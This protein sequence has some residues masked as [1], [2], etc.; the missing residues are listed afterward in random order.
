MTQSEER[1]HAS[2]VGF[3]I[4]LCAAASV[5]TFAVHPASGIAAAQDEC[6]WQTVASLGAGST[7]DAAG[8][9][10]SEAQVFYVYGGLSPGTGVSRAG[11]SVFTLQQHDTDPELLWAQRLDQ[12]AAQERWAHSG[13][14]A[15]RAGETAIYWIGG[16]RN[17]IRSAVITETYRA[18]N[19]VFEYLPAGY[20]QVWQEI[21]TIGSAPF[22]QDHAAVYY[23]TQRA[24]VIHGGR[25]EVVIDNHGYEVPDRPRA[26]SDVTYVL[27]YDPDSGTWA[28]EDFLTKSNG[29]RVYGHSLHYDED[30]A[31]LL[32]FGG[33]GDGID[34]ESTLWALDLANGLE[35]ASWSPLATEGTKPLGRF[36]HAASIDPA[37]DRLIVYGGRGRARH[38][39]DTWA[40]ELDA[41]PPQWRQLQPRPSAGAR[42]GAI[43]YYSVDRDAI[44]LAGGTGLDDRPQ[45]S[46]M[47]LRGCL[48]PL[49]TPTPT[50]SPTGT[51]TARSTAT[52]SSTPTATRAPATTTSTSTT[53]STAA[54]SATTAL[55][56]TP[57][58]TATSA[59]A[60]ST[61][62]PTA[63]HPT[64][65]PI[66]FFAFIP[67]ASQ[68][69]EL[70]PP[71]PT[72]SSTRT[73]VPTPTPIPEDCLF[74]E[75]EDNDTPEQADSHA[76]LCENLII[77][78]TMSSRPGD[79][80]SDDY[81]RLVPDFTG[82]VQIDLWNI[83]AENADFDLYLYDSGY[84]ELKY[85]YT[86]TDRE[87]IRLDLSA[88][89]HY[90]VRVW[91]AKGA[92]DRPYKL[93]WTTIR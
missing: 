57:T 12:P 83:D 2:Q 13:T 67:Y 35:N 46:V 9:Y 81:F 59:T 91:R 80:D 50:S 63:T 60:T 8:G 64:E 74:V 90:Y 54:P 77:E 56:A 28:W 48:R 27:M 78:G 39:N 55:P 79:D 34:G 7:R 36:N 66:V 84:R 4:G 52:V 31:R 93:Q 89:S 58:Y 19:T 73:P 65:P 70:V 61:V 3:A 10:S 6:T 15:E 21:S 40:L 20:G 1:P 32:L 42:V 11:R 88:D 33:T 17:D 82:R 69:S 29:P 41:D 76:R 37:R 14:V 24:I 71:T 45:S 22:L 49:P 5:L 43:A 72:A 75:I 25:E 30:R 92:S 47:E 62:T 87:T 53:T 26:V 86:E 44:I 38:L 18:T 85:S 68:G 51:G 16:N 23:P